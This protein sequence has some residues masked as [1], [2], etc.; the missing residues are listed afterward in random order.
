MALESPAGWIIQFLNFYQI[1]Q[2]PWQEI[3][4]KNISGNAP[5][6]NIWG[7]IQ[8]NAPSVP[9]IMWRRCVVL[10][11]C[12]FPQCAFLLSSI[13]SAGSSGK[14]LAFLPAPW[15]HYCWYIWCIS[16]DCFML[17]SSSGRGGC[18]RLVQARPSHYG[19]QHSVPHFSVHSLFVSS[20]LLCFVLARL[21]HTLVSHPAHMAQTLPTLIPYEFF[22]A[23]LSCPSILPFLTFS[24]SFFLHC[25][26][27][28][29]TLFWGPIFQ[30]FYLFCTSPMNLTSDL[31]VLTFFSQKQQLYHFLYHFQQYLYTAF[32]KK[33]HK[34]ILQRKTNNEWFPI[35]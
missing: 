2:L 4:E 9:L 33:I 14:A 28:S 30:P 34:A 24:L 22:M 29:H 18:H 6:C 1:P 3:P 10:F 27:F 17:I 23:P 25:I 31:T 7:A 35:T 19:L 11:T 5:G 15:Q 12:F 20:W 16:Y 8:T 21:P 26:P 13:Y 32:S